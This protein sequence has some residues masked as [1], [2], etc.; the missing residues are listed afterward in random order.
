MR[1]KGEK[2]YIALTV[3]VC[4]ALFVSVSDS[5][6]QAVGVLGEARNAGS[7]FIQS[8]SGQW[9]VAPS[10]YPVLQET[11]IR[12]DRGTAAIYF[13]DGSRVSLSNGTEGVIGGS[14]GSYTVSLSKGTLVFNMVPAASLTTTAGMVEVSSE[15]GKSSGLISICR[16]GT[17]VKNSSGT[18]NVR[19]NGTGSKVLG[20]GQSVFIG[21]DDQ[22]YANGKCDTEVAAVGG[23]EGGEAVAAA[24]TAGAAA[25]GASG[26]G[27][28]AAALGAGGAGIAQTGMLLGFSGGAAFAV[29]EGFSGSTGLASPSSP[30]AQRIR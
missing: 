15:K 13:R 12:T 14:I 8:A 27:A 4:A 24:S 18:V 23:G 6:A 25:A 2:F 19:V 5:F 7:T 30:G 10:S 22:F 3:I 1:G 9:Q 26:A 11:A 16:N 21:K 17:E 29:R 20:E 28:G